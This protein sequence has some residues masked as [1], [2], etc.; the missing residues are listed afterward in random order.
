[1]TPALLALCSA[2]ILAAGLLAAHQGP[3]RG[4]HQ[5]GDFVIGAIIS[6]GLSGLAWAGTWALVS[7]ALTTAAGGPS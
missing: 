5:D 6:V 1:M 4:P 7:W 3:P 2:P